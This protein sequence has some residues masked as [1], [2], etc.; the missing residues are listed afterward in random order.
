MTSI[1]R[2]WRNITAF[3]SASLIHVGA[4]L[5]SGGKPHSKL[6]LLPAAATFQGTSKTES[7]H[8][9]FTYIYVYFVQLCTKH[10]SSLHASVLFLALYRDLRVHKISPFVLTAKGLYCLFVY[11]NVVEAD[12]PYLPG[13]IRRAA[14]RLLSIYGTYK[15]WFRRF[16]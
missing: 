10:P 13:V 11:F 16:R 1:T 2:R 6:P 7:S 12:R 9:R 4:E 15:T 3:V 8:L 14:C 5:H